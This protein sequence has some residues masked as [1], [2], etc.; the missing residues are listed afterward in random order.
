MKRLVLCVVAVLAF[1]GC[2]SGGPELGAHLA[3][4]T[5]AAMTKPAPRVP[6]ALSI[7]GVKFDALTRAQAL[8]QLE[9]QGFTLTKEG[10]LCDKLTAPASFDR[11]AWLVACWYQRRWAFARLQWTSASGPTRFFSLA[12]SLTH[13]FGQPTDHDLMPKFRSSAFADWSIAGGRGAVKIGYG[14]EM[15]L[16]IEDVRITNA[17]WRAVGT[18]QARRAAHRA[19]GLGIGGR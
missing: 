1:A 3:T 8:A 13:K 9:R 18:A 10:P 4:A 5:P 14:L 11:A 2:S 19:A 16:T 12:R 17:L 7:A 6:L 15:H